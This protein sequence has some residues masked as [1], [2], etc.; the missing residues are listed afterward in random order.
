MSLPLR[1]IVRR[2]KAIEKEM[3]E[4]KKLYKIEAQNI[5]SDIFTKIYWL[6]VKYLG[7]KSIFKKT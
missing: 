4:T 7:W 3:E 1:A 2:I 5:K 6:K